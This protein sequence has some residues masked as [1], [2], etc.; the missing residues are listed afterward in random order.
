M[1]IASGVIH[2]IW[3]TLYQVIYPVEMDNW[4]I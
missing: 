3:F 4:Y 2:D 1:T